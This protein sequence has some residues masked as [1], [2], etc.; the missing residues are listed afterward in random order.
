MAHTTYKRDNSAGKKTPE[1]KREA[2]RMAMAMKASRR[3][4]KSV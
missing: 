4:K 1:Q 2:H 3:K